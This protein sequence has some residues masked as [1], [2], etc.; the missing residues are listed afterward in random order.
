MLMKANIAFM[1][2]PHNAMWALGKDY[3]AVCEHF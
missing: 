2:P 1:G 3:F